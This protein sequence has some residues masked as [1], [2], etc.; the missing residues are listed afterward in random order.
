MRF[1]GFYGNEAARAWLSGVFDSGREPHAILI[2]GPA[3]SGKKTLARLIAQAF[4]CEGTGERPCGECRQCRNAQAGVHPDI[5]LESAAGGA[6]SFS[7]DTVRRIRLDA[8]VA[9]NDAAVKVY[10][11]AGVHNMTESA[12]N[13]LLKILEEPPAHVRFILTCDG[14]SR[15]L[16]TVQSRCAGLTLGPLPEEQVTQALLRRDPALDRNQAARAAQLSG[17]LI[18]RAAEGLAQGGF[19]AAVAFTG[20]FTE[21]LGG[22]DA[23][24]FLRLSG[25]LEKNSELFRACLELLPLLFRD[26]IASRAGVSGRLSG[27]GEAAD[28]LRGAFTPRQLAAGVEI[29]LDAR[30]AADR[31]ANQRLLL[32]WFFARL[33]QAVHDV[34]SCGAG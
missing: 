23:F 4:V 20:G 32:T 17:G 8:F 16:G 22:S 33:W 18:G 9:P 15:V 30:A 21:A 28:R 3:G 1:N 34:A 10:I 5:R 24:A 14:R 31:Y 7:V 25:T 29:C 2:D 19:S 13:A 6:R 27:C 12:Q 26:A 11:L